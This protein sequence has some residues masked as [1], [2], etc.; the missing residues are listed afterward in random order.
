MNT[1]AL[2]SAGILNIE[3]FVGRFRLQ[4]FVFSAASIDF[5]V[6]AFTW[7]L[8]V[9][10]NP[11]ER[12]NVISLTLGNGLAFPIYEDNVIEARFESVTTNIS[13]GDYYWQ[14]VR[15]D[16]NEPWLNGKAKFSFGPLGSQ[17]T[18]QEATIN[19]VD[20][21]VSVELSAIV[22]G[23]GSFSALTGVPGDNAALA[24][25]L[26][27][28]QNLLNTA[29][30]LVDAATIDLTAIKHT[31]STA[32]SRTFTISYTGDDIT[33]EVTLTATSATQTFPA[34]ALCVSEGVASGN[35][36]LAMAGVSGDKYMIAIKKVG[37]VYYVVS[38]NFGQ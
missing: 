21:E 19:L 24:A 22:D 6:S 15:T 8:L 26:A 13:E 3:L 7:Q 18:A 32:A 17:G 12:L 16:T 38:K 25:A 20:Q 31:L 4:R 23:S 29:T 37:S 2:H 9:K 35:N 5:D 30:A 27:L 10:T 36:T 33:I 14:L 34:T 11:G 28:K 1:A